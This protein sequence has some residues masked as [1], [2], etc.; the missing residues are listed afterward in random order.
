MVTVDGQQVPL[1]EKD[2]LK[3]EIYEKSKK[4]SESILLASLPNQEAVKFTG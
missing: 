2:A 3:L 1:D 4:I